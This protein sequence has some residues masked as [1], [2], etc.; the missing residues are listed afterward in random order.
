LIDFINNSHPILITTIVATIELIFAIV[1]SFIIAIEAI[2][3]SFTTTRLAFKVVA[4]M[5]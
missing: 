4:I 1:Y 5:V 2:I 3:M